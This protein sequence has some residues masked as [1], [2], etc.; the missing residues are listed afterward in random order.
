[1]QHGAWTYEEDKLLAKYQ[2]LFSSRPCAS[3][4]RSCNPQPRKTVCKWDGTVCRQLAVDCICLRWRFGGR[5][6]LLMWVFWSTCSDRPTRI[7]ALQSLS[8]SHCKCSGRAHIGP[9]FRSFVALT[10]VV[11]WP[12]ALSWSQTKLIRP[13][14]RRVCLYLHRLAYGETSLSR[15]PNPGK[16]RWSRLADVVSRMVYLP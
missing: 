8:C 7:V 5:L 6:S 10:E 1:M 15:R 2:V 12:N 11:S 4:S 16:A 13:N 9:A 3:P 14:M